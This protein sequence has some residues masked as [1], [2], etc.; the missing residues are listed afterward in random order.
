MTIHLDARIAILSCVL[1]AASLTAAQDAAAGKVRFQ[2]PSTKLCL[3]GS[4]TV[5]ARVSTAA[6][7][8]TAAAQQWIW[9]NESSGY[10]EFKNVGTGQCLRSVNGV[11]STATCSTSSTYQNFWPLVISNPG[12]GQPYYTMIAWADPSGSVSNS[13]CYV[14]F[15][16]TT[17]TGYQLYGTGRC[18]LAA[19]QLDY[20]WKTIPL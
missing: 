13:Y 14:N 2:S 20:T 9:T 17:V 10:A 6:C 18:I 8:S 12:G 5:G 16:S 15:S 19:T 4:T 11:L 7:S 1:C 3:K